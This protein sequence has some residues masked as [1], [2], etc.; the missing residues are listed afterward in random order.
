MVVFKHLN[1]AEDVYPSPFNNVYA[2][3]MIFCRNVLMYFSPECA[4]KAINGFYQTLTDNGL[5]I[6]SLTESIKLSGSSFDA[7]HFHGT[8]LYQKSTKGRI[9][10]EG[11]KGKQVAGER[12]VLCNTGEN[13]LKIFQLPAEGRASSGTRDTFCRDLAKSIEGERTGRKSSAR[14]MTMRCFCFEQGRY[15]EVEE[16]ISAGRSM[17]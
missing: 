14:R 4:K 10:E 15:T 1:L 12:K 9:I 5:L 8:T 3:D 17:S 6:V 2:M 7:I 16:I 13:N 11:A